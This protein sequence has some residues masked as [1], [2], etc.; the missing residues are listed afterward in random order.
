LWGAFSN[1]GQVCTAIER[2]LVHKNIYNAFKE[3]FLLQ[4]KSL[5]PN[6]DF[7]AIVNQLQMEKVLEQIQ[8]SIQKGDLLLTGGQ[9]DRG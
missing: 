8:N 3:K 4:V 2:I 1:N 6:I 7:G 5:R 9:K